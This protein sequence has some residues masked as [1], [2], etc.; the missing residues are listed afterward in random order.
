[1]PRTRPWSPPWTRWASSASA[2]SPSP[3][4]P[5]PAPRSPGTLR[6]E[7]R[8]RGRAAAEERLADL[9]PPPRARR[10]LLAAAAGGAGRHDGGGRRRRRL[11]LAH[12]AADQRRLRGPEAGHGGD[13]A[14]GHHRPVPAAR[15]RHL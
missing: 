13:P 10:A 15:R 1:A 11:R 14:A 2:A 6:N 8:Q 12:G 7:P 9:P 5:S 4:R 3:P